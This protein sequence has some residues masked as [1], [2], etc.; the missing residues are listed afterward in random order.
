MFSCIGSRIEE[1][2]RVAKRRVS[3]LSKLKGK[4]VNP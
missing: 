4:F 1:K 2:K 3:K